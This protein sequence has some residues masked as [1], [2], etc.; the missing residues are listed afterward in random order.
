ML[1]LCGCSCEEY[2]L[3][4]RQLEA[5]VQKQTVECWIF[6]ATDFIIRHYDLRI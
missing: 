3:T 2:N 4:Q 1:Y 5:R 6:G